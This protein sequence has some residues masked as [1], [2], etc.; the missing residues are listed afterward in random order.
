[1]SQTQ[2]SDA[3][4][5]KDVLR[6]LA[7]DTRV[8]A[9]EVGVTVHRGTVTLS[10][11]VDNWGKRLAAQAAAHRVHG[12]LDVAND[13]VVKL[14]GS[15]LRDD[16]DLAHAIRFAL[17]WDVSV[18]DEKIRS[19]VAGGV[20]TL[21]GE[22][23]LISQREDAER[24][25]SHLAGVRELRN[26][27]RVVPSRV[28]E[29]IQ[30]AIQAALARHAQR[31]AEQIGLKIKDGVVEVSGRVQSWAEKQLVLG[32]AKGT[33]GVSKVDDHVWIGG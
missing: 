20:V 7:W 13:L 15:A 33:A 16:T 6:E 24:A 1:M 9:T 32:A 27:I 29:Q 17:K 26:Q 4:I 8:S 18:P 28:G 3:E 10:G 22:V 31:E 2:K 11:T 5:Q 12:V 23:D 30:T 21:E 25:V 14:A 19:T